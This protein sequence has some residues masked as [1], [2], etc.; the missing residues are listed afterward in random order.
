MTADGVELNTKSVRSAAK[1]PI[2]TLVVQSCK[3]GQVS[4]IDSHRIVS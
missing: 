2:D 3:R 4:S 1:T